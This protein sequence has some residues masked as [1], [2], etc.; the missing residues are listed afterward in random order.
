MSKRCTLHLEHQTLKR[1]KT[2]IKRDLRECLGVV[3][4]RSDSQELLDFIHHCGRV[5]SQ[6][7][8]IYDH[9]LHTD[10]FCNTVYHII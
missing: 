5:C 3:E 2:E 4:V 9:H 8:S 7:M 10:A 6:L 1:L